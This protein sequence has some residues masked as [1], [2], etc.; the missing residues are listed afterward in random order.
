MD[1]LSWT[2][3]AEASRSQATA[4]RVGPPGRESVGR[5]N[6]RSAIRNR[7]I[8]RIAGSLP[9]FMLGIVGV[10]ASDATA[11]H[12]DATTGRALTVPDAAHGPLAVSKTNP[13]YFTVVGNTAGQRRHQSDPIRHRSLCRRL[14]GR[15]VG[16][17][18]VPAWQPTRSDGHLD[19]VD[20]EP[21]GE[22]A[23]TEYALVNPGKEYLVLQP[24]VDAGG[25]TVD[26]RQGTYS[27]E[28]YS[29]DRRHAKGGGKVVVDANGPTTF[30][31][32][33]SQGASVL[34]LKKTGT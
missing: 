33:F 16:L 24:N 5:C 27:A 7:G 9:F 10:R 18:D 22:I 25:F 13:R 4:R 32:P 20:M 11:V 21:R 6:A 23:S 28:W 1:D 30:T 29:V 34:Y 3:A 26:N 17:E 15:R 2:C 19:L 12:T 31:P 14:G 8:F